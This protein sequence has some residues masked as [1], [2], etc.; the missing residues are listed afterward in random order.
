MLAGLGITVEDDLQEFRSYTKGTYRKRKVEESIYQTVAIRALLDAGKGVRLHSVFGDITLRATDIASSEGTSVRASGG[1]VNLL[2]T[3]ETDHYSYSLLA[4]GYFTI[5]SKQVG[6]TIETGVPNTI[7]GGFAVE[8]LRGVT[9]EYEGDPSLSLDEQIERLSQFEGLEWMAELRANAPDVDWQAVELQYDTWRISNTSLTPAVAAVIA[10]VVSIATSGAASAFATAA[11]G[12]VTTSVGTAAT[13]S[14]AA[15]AAGVSSAISQ[16]AVALANGA[17][18]GDIGGALEEL[19][20]SDTLRTVAIAIVTAGALQAVDAA[21]FDVSTGNPESFLVDSV[22]VSATG[23]VEYALSLA[24]QSAQAVTHAAVETGVRVLAEGG[25]LG[26]FEEFFLTALGRNVIDIVGESFAKEIG[27]A[28]KDRRI[29]DATKYI[30]HAALGCVLGAAQSEFGGNDGVDIERACASGAGGAVVGELVAEAVR[31]DFFSETDALF[32]DCLEGAGSDCKR[33]SLGEF[34]EMFARYKRSGVDFARL[35][36]ALAAFTF[37]GDVNIAAGTGANAA[38]HNAFWFIPLAVFSALEKAW[39]VYEYATWANELGEALQRNDAVGDARVQELLKE[40]ALDFSL[41]VGASFIP[42]ASTFKRIASNL[43]RRFPGAPQIAN[44][45]DDY[46]LQVD[47]GTV[48]RIRPTANFP[49]PRLEHHLRPNTPV[50]YP[51]GETFFDSFARAATRN[52]NSNKVVLESGR[53][54]GRSYI[55]VANEQDASY[56]QFVDD[57]LTQDEI[58]E[59]NETFLSQQIQGMKEIILSHDPATA[60]GFFQMEVEYLE[61]NLFHFVEDNGIWRAVR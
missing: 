11:V 32:R 39:T 21:F 61:E 27:D 44:D 54:N 31:S 17:V 10:V 13:I 18:N 7:V 16:A 28:S 22:G 43:R 3:T 29:N 36:A 12:A 20:S 41:E 55:D 35:S 14:T 50:R 5:E 42:G 23:E 24:G 15:I 48:E 37:G 57:G 40:R 19:G 8:A 2:M 30:A 26:D 45:L 9:V 38:E 52:P 1:G 56:L 47:R 34:R 53:G 25:N 6:H 49:E 46:A 4:K 58:W 59:V 51:A 33:L 60:T